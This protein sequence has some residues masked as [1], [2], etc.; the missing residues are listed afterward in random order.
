M[1]FGDKQQQ[2]AVSFF[3]V[4]IV[5]VIIS[6]LAI[7][8]LPD[9]SALDHERVWA[10]AILGVFGGPSMRASGAAASTGRFGAGPPIR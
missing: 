9:K 7:L 4:M 5:I 6:I 1:N 3:E 2:R 8:V 10:A